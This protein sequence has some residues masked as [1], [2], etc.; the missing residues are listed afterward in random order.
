MLPNFLSAVLLFIQDD[1]NIQQFRGS[2][3]DGFI[4]F[5]SPIDCPFQ[6]GSS[7]LAEPEGTGS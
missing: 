4:L 6:R 1:E 3:F 2:A 5:R 7:A